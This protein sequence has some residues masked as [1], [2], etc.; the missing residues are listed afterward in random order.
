V[1]WKAVATVDRPTLRR[2]KW[3][4]ALL[5]AVGTDCLV[6]LAGAVLV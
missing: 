3:N 6:E 5:A 4:F 1:L 2:L